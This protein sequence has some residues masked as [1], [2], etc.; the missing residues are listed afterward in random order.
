MAPL[1]NCGGTLLARRRDERVARQPEQVR[2]ALEA[3]NGDPDAFQLRALRRSRAYPEPGETFRLE[4]PCCPPLEGVVVNSHVDPME[5]DA[6][7][8][9]V[10][11]PGVSPAAALSRYREQEWMRNVPLF[12]ISRMTFGLNR[13]ERSCMQTLRP[14]PPFLMMP[15]PSVAS[16]S[17]ITT[18]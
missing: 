9:L 5:E 11:A 2:R 14:E 17:T 15:R 6:I 13:Y 10:F 1:E 18:R 7:V 12:A 16:S 8:A 4:P 3:L